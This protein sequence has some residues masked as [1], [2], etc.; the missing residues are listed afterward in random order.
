MRALI[1]LIPIAMVLALAISAPRI[2]AVAPTCITEIPAAVGDNFAVLRGTLTATG[3]TTPVTPKFRFGTSPTLVGATDY[4]AFPS[5]LSGIGQVFNRTQY[6]LNPGVTYYYA[7]VCTNAD[8][9]SIAGAI[10]SFT[11]T[12]PSRLSPF[13]IAFF[14]LF[15]ILLLL[16]LR[17][18]ILG[19]LA[20]ATGWFIALNLF[21][22][23]LDIPMAI[24]M[25]GF[26]T[27]IFVWSMFRIL[28]G[29][30]GVET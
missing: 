7:S 10:I 28:A 3:G 8:G 9:T 13:L 30:T 6:N 24:L 5:Q 21:T 27:V 2:S 1:A 25:F 16:S 15:V 26:A 29:D 22:Q 14:I 20:G 19:L 11:T 12:P 4:L 17:F 23:F 18:P